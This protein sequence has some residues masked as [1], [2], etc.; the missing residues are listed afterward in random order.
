MMLKFL[1][2]NKKSSLKNLETIL[3]KRKFYQKK[4]I[5]NV[6]KIILNVKKRGDKAVIMYEKKFSKI[7]NKLN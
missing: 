1:N 4:E 5:V 7:K 6:K 3:N 2:Y